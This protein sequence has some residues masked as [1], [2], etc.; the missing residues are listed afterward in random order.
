MKSLYILPLLAALMLPSCSILLGGPSLNEMETSEYEDLKHKVSTITALASSRLARNWD[1]E[2]REKALEV[3]TQS[4][5]FII[6]NVFGDLN[7]TD[8]IRVLMNNYGDRLGLDVDARR[9]IKDAALA[10]DLLVGPIELGIDGSLGERER[11]LILA[12]LSGLELGLK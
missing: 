1:A 11:D 4:R 9:D 6:G 5:A 7:T 3:I 12:L 8:I 10:I 2:K